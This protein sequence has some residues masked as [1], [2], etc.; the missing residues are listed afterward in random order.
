[1]MFGWF[2]KKIDADALAKIERLHAEAR[3]LLARDSDEAREQAYHRCIQALESIPEPREEWPQSAP[4]F[5]TLGDM[6]SQAGD[7]EAALQAYIDAIRCKDALGTA[8]IHLRLGKAQF[9]L[10][11]MDRAADEL[12][13]AYLCSAEETAGMAVFAGQDPKYFEFLKTR[14]QP[15]PDGW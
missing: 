13:R 10:G 2:K 1:M 14:M 7:F 9:E 3:D 4:L 6:Y 5:C 15:P 12:C 11:E 8:D